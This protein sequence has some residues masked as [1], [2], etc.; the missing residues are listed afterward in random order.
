MGVLSNSQYWAQNLNKMAGLVPP[1]GQAIPPKDAAEIR[2]IACSA[3]SNLL[4]DP[5]FR[6]DLAIATDLARSV[7]TMSAS[8]ASEFQPFL[9]RFMELESK[10]LADAHIDTIASRDLEREIRGSASHPSPVPLD[11]LAD[12]IAFCQSLACNAGA[13]DDPKRP[14][15]EVAWRGTKGV[16]LLGIDI[17]STIGSAVVLGPGGA[18]AVGS[19][20]A[21]SC[22]YGADILWDALKGR[23]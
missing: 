17:G 8:K 9:N 3:L 1:L 19:V 2:A 18:A 20:A 13:V 10:I 7:D 5:E 6:K 16:G 22:G 12:M 11:R 4:A 15:W 23:W 14:L 21:F